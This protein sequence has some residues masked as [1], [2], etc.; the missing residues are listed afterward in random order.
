M[1][2]GIILAA[3]YGTRLRPITNILPKALLPFF[4]QPLIFHIM[5]KMYN[6]GMKRFYI[7]VH[8][9]KDEIIKA[10]QASEYSQRVIFQVEE[11]LLLTGGGLK[12]LLCKVKSIN[13][14]VHNVDIIEEFDY[15]TLWRHHLDKGYDITWV[16]SDSPGSVIV[17]EDEI[18][19][20]GERGFTFTGVGIYGTH[21]VNYMPSGKFHLIPWLAYAVSEG[22]I[23]MGFVMEKGFWADTGTAHG[24]FRAY[25]HYMDGMKKKIISHG[26]IRGEVRLNGYVYI[27]KGVRIEGYGY[28][29]NSL[30]LGKTALQGKIGLTR[31]IM[32]ANRELAF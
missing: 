31:K 24:L 13:A 30:I 1:R 23:R 12:N 7:N 19:G 25:T 17:D 20:F 29:E 14:L 9:L 22:K 5:N 6:N 3:G 4:E 21:I 16:L 15:E 10:I 27:G 28:I 26:E 2:E 8:Y 18:V 11:E 32:Y